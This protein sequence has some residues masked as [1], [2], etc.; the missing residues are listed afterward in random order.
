MWHT[1]IFAWSSLNFHFHPK[2]TLSTSCPLG[3]VVPRSST[4]NILFVYFFVAWLLLG[5]H[6]KCS[7]KKYPELQSRSWWPVCPPLGDV[8]PRSTLL[9]IVSRP[10]ASWG[11]AVRRATDYIC[12]DGTAFGRKRKRKHIPKEKQEDKFLKANLSLGKSN[13]WKVNQR[14]GTNPEKEKQ[15]PKATTMQSAE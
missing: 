10:T 3:D 14:E 6:P 1:S 13:P 15:H 12:D 11:S 8:V 4:L 5:N 7:P 2:V 9:N